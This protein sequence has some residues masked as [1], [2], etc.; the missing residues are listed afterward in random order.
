[1][2]LSL[3]GKVMFGGLF[4]V[5]VLLKEWRCCSSCVDWQHF[6]KQ[7]S[8]VGNTLDPLQKLEESIADSSPP[9]LVPQVIL[10]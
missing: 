6:L 2:D 1:M 4:E 9:A 5:T 7:C 3:H 10:A 8:M